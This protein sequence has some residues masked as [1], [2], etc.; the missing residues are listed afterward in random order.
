MVEP[1]SGHM[2]P[3]VARLASGSGS[4][5]VAVELD[6]LADHAVLAQHLGDRQH[7]VGGGGALGQLAGE[8]EADHA[9]DEHRHRLAEHRGL[10]LDA[11]DAP[12]DHADAVDHRGVGVGA[13]EGVGVGR[14]VPSTRGEDRA[15]EVLDVDLV[16]RCRCRAGPP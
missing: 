3:M 6:E 11:A 7:E 12:A 8:L 10:G 13:D 5:A 2:L 15:G 9:R 14:S 1:N 4:D 16:A